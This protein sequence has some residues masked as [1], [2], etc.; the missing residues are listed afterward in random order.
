MRLSEE[1]TLALEMSARDVRKALKKK[2]C[3]ELRQNGSHLQMKCQACQT[4]I[5][6]HGG[7]IK[8][9]TLHSIKKSVHTCV[10]DIQ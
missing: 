7:D 9:G 4:T 6:M 8:K 10:G 3:E 2:G 5:P 1:L